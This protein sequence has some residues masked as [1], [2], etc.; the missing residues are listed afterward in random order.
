MN[1]LAEADQ[2]CRNAAMYYAIISPLRAIEFSILALIQGQVL[3]GLGKSDE[4]L[5]LIE[6][7]A[8][9]FFSFYADKKKYVEARTIYAVVLLKRQEY[10]RALTALEESARMAAEDK[11]TEVLAYILNNIG[12]CWVNLGNLQKAKECLTAAAEMFAARHLRAESVRV[13]GSLALLLIRLGKFNEAVSEYYIC[14]S[15]FLEL[16]MPLVAA[17]AGLRVVEVLFLA[18]R[19]SQV[20]SLCA[21]LV[22]T[23]TDA[24]LPREAQKALAHLG[25]LAR[26]RKADEPTVR[27]VREFMEHLEINPTAEFKPGPDEG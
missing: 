18:G 20:P 13:R 23:F 21:E 24:K 2:A 4:G 19:T 22:K 5:R 8:H 7:H 25:E 9:L 1:D 26:L 27:F 15:T 3:H 14:R 10:S 6:R 17:Q 16:D 11:D 12:I